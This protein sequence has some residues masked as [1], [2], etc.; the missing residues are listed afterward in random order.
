MGASEAVCLMTAFIVA[1]ILNRRNRI[2]DDFFID[3]QYAKYEGEILYV[4]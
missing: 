4:E 1:I 2:I 3:R